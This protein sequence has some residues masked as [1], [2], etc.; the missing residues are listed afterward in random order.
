MSK[1]NA[2]SVV[3]PVVPSDRE[4]TLAREAQAA[5]RAGKRA[6]I[7]RVQVLAAGETVAVDLPPVVTRL[8]LAILAETA[9][10][11]ALSL[12][13]LETELTTHQAAALLSVSRPYLIGLV[14]KGVLPARLVG[15]HRRLPLKDVLAYKGETFAERSR[16]LDE[17]VAHDQ[18]LGLL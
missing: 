6:D 16:G 14:D 1:R 7:P 10:G 15:T 2:T 8:L 13:S 12:A 3:D 11:H 17:L 9:A 18:K 5:L 4:A